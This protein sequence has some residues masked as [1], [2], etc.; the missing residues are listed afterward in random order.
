MKIKNVKHIFSRELRDQLRDRRTLFTV[1]VMPMLLYPL[2]GVALLQVSQFMRQNPTQVWLVGTENL[3]AEPNL[4]SAGRFDP[5]LYPDGKTNSVQIRKVDPNSDGFQ[6]IIK[7]YL[8]MQTL[9]DGA[10]AADQMIQ[11]EL[12]MRDVD[13]AVF[14]S[15]PIVAPDQAVNRGVDANL[16]VVTNPAVYI[17]HNSASDQSRIGAERVATLLNRWQTAYQTEALI[18]NDLPATIVSGIE[19]NQSDIAHKSGKQAAMWSKILPFIIVIWAL[20]GAFYPAIDLCAGEKERGTFETLLS[21]PAARSEIAIGKLLTVMSFSAATSLLNL[22]SMGFTGIFVATKMGGSEGLAGLPIGMPPLDSFLWLVIGL[23]PI[24]AFFSALA[25]AAAAFARS[26]KE[27]QYY[28]V[29]LMMISMPLM[30][31][32]MMPGT[33]LDL[34]TSL[35][36]IS[37]LMLL[38]RGLIEGRLAECIQ[39]AAPVGLVTF[40]CC[41]FSIKWVIHQFNSETV[42]FRASERFSPT[43]WLVHLVRQ[44]HDLPTVG[45]A[46][47]CG[48]VILVAKFFIGFVARTPNTFSEFALQTGIILVATIAVPALMMAL[49]LTRNPRKSLRLN[50]CTLPMASAAVLAAIFLNP[51]ITWISAAVMQMYPPGDNLLVLEQVIA[52][53]MGSAPGLWALILVFAVAPAVTEELAF[54]GFILSGLQS[55]KNKWHAILICS[56]LFGIAHSVIQQ[57]MITFVVGIV[58][59]IIAVQ[60]RSLIPCILFHAVHNS[61]AIL[62]SQANT[63]FVESSPL[64][65]QILVSENGTAY[66]YSFP[67][68]LIMTVL[69]VGLI[70]WFLRLPRN[71]V[72]TA[73]HQ[74]VGIPAPTASMQT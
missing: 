33:Q 5:Q 34:G 48:L 43:G 57:S 55:L 64:L 1:V 63:Q 24:A 2:M 53:I 29:P 23:V 42:L 66:Q 65:Q 35:I 61:L 11:H 21:S 22:I 58:L 17:F 37:G 13:V 3:P 45:N 30:M 15:E 70:V 72:T 59:G 74:F 56:L 27:G 54:R 60:T 68:G 25:L 12:Q 50:A 62:V 47:L 32:P 9:E 18:Q 14:F 16:N 52:K 69:G 51:L 41:W 10:Q 44:R 38:L 6:D 4:M 28:L 31:V 73:S 20:T 36:P 71:E 40:A 67:A 19:I 39:F 7:R 49:V 8:A 46:I 26:S